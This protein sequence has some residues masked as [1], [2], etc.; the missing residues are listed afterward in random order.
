MTVKSK[1]LISVGAV[2]AMAAIISGTW[3]GSK[4]YYDKQKPPIQVVNETPTTTTILQE[5]PI[6]P[7][8]DKW[9]LSPVEITGKMT[10][11]K[12]L[13][14]A[15]DGYKKGEKTFT[16]KAQVPDFKKNIIL[17]NYI[18]VF[19]YGHSDL[20]FSHGA[21]VEY[22]RM[23]IPNVGIGGGIFATNRELGVTAGLIIQ[24]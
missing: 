16:F 2:V 11:Y 15:S 21:K 23:L 19:G 4:A 8:W 24:F 10:G 7:E 5:V 20:S 3:F 14:T 1:V 22:Y 18:G 6:S 9:K 13:V 12:F 17:L